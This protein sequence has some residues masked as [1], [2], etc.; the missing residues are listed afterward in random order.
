MT[1]FHLNLSLMT[2]GHFRHAW[3]LPHADPL[4]Y[5]DIDHFGRLA[6]IAE[7]AKIDAIFLGDGPALRGEIEE[8]PGTGLDPLVLLGHL[9]ATTRNLGVVITSSTTYNSPYNLARR[10]QA[11]D[12]VTRGRAAVNIVTT[13]TPAAA[14]NFGLTAHPDKQTRYRR[15]YEFLDVATRLWDG[16]DPEAIVA[17]KSS[18]RYADLARIH[19]IDHVGEFFS[20]AGPLPVPAGPQ[21][22]PVI[23]Q[24]G[25]S[26]GGLALAGTFADVVFTVAQT[27]SAATAFRDEIRRRAASA[28][29]H[30]DDVKVS[31]GVVVLVAATE[32]EARHR[33]Q[34]LYATLPID[35]LTAALTRNLGLPDG[36]YGPDDPIT[37]DDLPDAIPGDA[38]S[39]GF[40]AAT[41]AL[42]AAGPRTPR[43]L[44]QRGAGGSGH[45]LLVGSAEQVAD[46]L[47]GW[48]EAGTADGFTV[49]PADTSVD[50]ENFAELVVPILQRRGL[51]QREYR[52][53]TLRARLGLPLPRRQRSPRTATPV[54]G[55]GGPELTSVAA[56]YGD[57]AA[58]LGVATDTIR[59]QLAHRS[60]R[61]F[62]P[63]AVTDD[64]LTAL[65]A[66]AQSAATSS[67]L[68]PWSVVAVRD[69]ARRARLAALA[70]NQGFIAQAPLFLVWIADLGRAHRLADRG[71]APLAA[72][73]YLESTLIGFVDTALAAQNA[74]VAAESLGLGTVF[75]GAIRNHPEQVAAELALPPHAVATFGLAVGAPDPAERAGV[76]PRLPLDAV[77]HRERYDADAADGHI[78]TYDKRLGAYN[79]RYGLP[80]TWSDRLLARLRGPESMAGRHRLREALARLGL[81]SR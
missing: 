39:A 37:V 77:L 5:L 45:R 31:L 46:D 21:G 58:T 56:R 11:L 22:R 62:G 36:V 47:Q 2:P 79:A 41:R 10:F 54:P 76:K 70:G 78:G 34:Q 68:Q 7:A 50:L 67:N 15:A 53:P 73:D 29:R 40:S 52:H 32:E 43:E 3:R 74:V 16:W 42:I 60:V 18:G 35:R 17:D 8:A 26:P 75:V 49:M 1:G 61:R 44:V 20:V 24:A 4:A 66:A 25:G 12:H 13:G 64:E 19:Q 23:V 57:P 38:F 28:G 27:R 48:Y 59:G 80:G 14:A 71:G 63:R 9:A 30:P 33:E 72:T 69:P 6:R 51:F 65:V 55:N 81:P